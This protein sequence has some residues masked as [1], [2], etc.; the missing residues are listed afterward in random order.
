MMVLEE[1][2]E[3]QVHACLLSMPFS[4]CPF[5]RLDFKFCNYCGLPLAKGK[6]SY[7]RGY[8]DAGMKAFHYCLSREECM[9]RWMGAVVTAT[10]S[11]LC[12]E[13]LLKRA[14]KLQI[15]EEARFREELEKRRCDDAH[16]P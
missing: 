14:E 5:T 3:R 1:G 16:H 10:P 15:L 11:I 12:S 6:R 8:A 7:H 9:S 2:T 13:D 4:P